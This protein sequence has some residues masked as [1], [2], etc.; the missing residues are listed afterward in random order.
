MDALLFSGAQPQPTPAHRSGDTPSSGAAG[1][2]AASS[3]SSAFPLVDPSNAIPTFKRAVAS[4]ASAAALEDAA[5]QMGAVVRALVSA[6]LGDALYAQAAED[7]AVLRDELV[8]LEEP[9]LYNAFAADLKRKLLDG[10]LGGDRRHMWWE[11]RRLRLG[12]V[13]NVESEVSDVAPDEAAKVSFER[14]RCR[15][16]EL[17]FPVSSTPPD[18][19][20]MLNVRYVCKMNTQGWG[21][22]ARSRYWTQDGLWSFGG[23]LLFTQTRRLSHEN[24]MPRGQARLKGPAV[25][26]QLLV[27]IH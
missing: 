21:G 27:Q 2:A 14:W 18:E 4:A 12:L 6:S 19:V 5:A 26:S 15:V 24:S 7:L 9:A 10:E 25:S 3:S 17:T 13:D 16:L 20:V 1:L 23:L 8:A 22:L 11:V